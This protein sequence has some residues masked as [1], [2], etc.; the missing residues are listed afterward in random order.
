M[1]F[2][3]L[4]LILTALSSCESIYLTTRLLSPLVPRPPVDCIPS[5]SINSTHKENTWYEIDPTATST[6]GVYI[7]GCCQGP[8]DIPDTVAQ[9]SS[10]AARILAY[11]QKGEVELEPITAYIA[12]EL[13]SGCRTCITVCP[14]N[15]ISYIKEENISEVNDALCKGCGTCVATCPSGAACQKHYRDS[16]IIAEIEGLLGKHF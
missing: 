13:C 7:A 9:A 1:R 14:Y 10:A 15:A 5:T 4:L 2:T 11:I 16:Q 12:P 3:T 8:K 6:D